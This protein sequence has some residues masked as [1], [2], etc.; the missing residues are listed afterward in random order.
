LAFR[1]VEDEFGFCKI[2]AAKDKYG[3]QVL[4]GMAITALGKP[5]AV[6]TDIEAMLIRAMALKNINQNNF[7]TATEWTQVNYHDA[8]HYLEKV[9][10]KT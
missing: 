5:S 3:L 7:A 8:T 9:A 2:Q 6:I 1:T 10:V 4:G